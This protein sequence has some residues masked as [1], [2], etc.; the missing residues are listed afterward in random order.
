M[1]VFASESLRAICHRLSE[2]EIKKLEDAEALGKAL[3]R[4]IENGN[5]HFFY[6]IIKANTDSLIAPYDLVLVRSL[7]IKRKNFL[8]DAIAFRE[9]KIARLIHTFPLGQLF[10]TLVDSNENNVL[11]IAGQLAP[12]LQLS[13]ISGAA[14]Q[15]QRE[16]QWFKEV[17]RHVGQY[18]KDAKNN[19]GETAYQVFAREHKGLLK[20]AEDW[21]KGL[22]NSYIVVGAL[23]ITIMVAA[24]F[25]L[26]GGNNQ[27]EGSP[28]FKDKPAFIV[29]IISD[30]ISL[31]AAAASILIFLGFHTARYNM[32]DFNKSIPNKL[33]GGLSTLFISLAAM[34]VAF[35]SAIF[36]MI[37]N[38]SWIII[39]SV[40]LAGIP[41]SLFAWLQF[42]FLVE[43]YVLTYRSPIFKEKTSLASKI[44]ALFCWKEKIE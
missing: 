21:M 3:T 31:F 11:H 32:E 25:T 19:N 22:A 20:E 16:I 7:V 40:L 37:E 14:L 39:P 9:E 1:H 4:A 12:N 26:P 27:N 30:A 34:M 44:K 41:I 15:M 42:P 38:R 23:I 10:I 28:M 17:E 29:Y 8:M 13:R 36:L 43:I 18:H 6:E 24:A 2:L 33:M 35:C 5:Y